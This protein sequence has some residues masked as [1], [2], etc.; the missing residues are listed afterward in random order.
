MNRGEFLSAAFL[1]GCEAC[2]EEIAS[3][4]GIQGDEHPF[5]VCLAVQAALAENGL[6]I[7]PPLP[8]GDLRSPRLVACALAKAAPDDIF[9]DIAAGESALLEFKSTLIFD[10]QRSRAAPQSTR[11]QLKSDDVI[12]SALKTIAAFL[13]SDGGV[14]L[15]GVENDGSIFGLAQ[16]YEYCGDAGN[17]TWEL[18][19]RNLIQTRFHD[20]RSVNNFVRLSFVEIDGRCVARVVVTRRNQFS[21]VKGKSGEYEL[22]IRQGNRTVR[23]SLPEAEQLWRARGT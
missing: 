14:L 4:F 5:E 20:G 16:D 11:E 13:N 3:I 15:I 7:T 8:K 6:Q 19:L 23:L 17:D 22:Y 10:V 12:L 9:R 1:T 2:I 18:T 21:Y